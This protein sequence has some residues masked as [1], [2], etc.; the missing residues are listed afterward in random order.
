MHTTTSSPPVLRLRGLRC[1]YP[2]ESGSVHALRGVDLDVAA[3]SFT[4]IMG[5]SGSG[6]TTLLHCAA[7]LQTPTSGHVAFDGQPLEAMDQTELAKLRRRRIGFVF[8]SFNLLPA[9]STVDNVELPVR[10]DGRRPDRDRTLALL[11]GVGLRER[12]GHRPDQLSGGQRQRVA[13]ARALITDPEV[14]FADEPTGALD[15][16]SARE[17]LTLLRSL[18]DQGQTIIMV[19]HDPIAASYSDEVLFLADGSL[20][21]RV[22]RP[23]AREVANRMAVLVE[24]AERAAEVRTR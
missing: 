4:A 11:A 8:Q 14:V 21:D 20:V 5:P 23:S 13:I 16:R 15:I 10:L 1:E 7:G 18:A 22:A 3:G 6:K 12:A 9:L 19:T 24:S 17:V 2:G